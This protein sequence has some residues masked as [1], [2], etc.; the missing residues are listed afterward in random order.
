MDIRIKRYKKEFDHSFS[1]GVYPT[2]ELLRHRQKETLGV[3]VH[4][5]GLENSGVAKIREFCRNHSI[6]FEI[7]EKT[8]SRV[9]ARENDYAVGIFRKSERPLEESANHIILVHPSGMGNLGTII[10]TMLGFGFQDLAIIE[11]GADLFHPET[12]RA[13][14]G[15]IFQLRSS[16]FDHFDDYRARF[17]RKFY[18]LMTDGT[19]PLQEADFELPFGLIFGNEST[20]LP[21]EFQNYGSSLRI[22]QADTVDS[23]NLAVSVGITLYETNRKKDQM[24]I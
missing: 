16:R 17:P 12:V 9:G 19:I 2:L 22:P 23:L 15:A 4:P 24:T 7:Q 3:V 14:M 1:F 11:P 10:R 20:G 13:S 21:L 5:Q 8:F 6:P 18:S